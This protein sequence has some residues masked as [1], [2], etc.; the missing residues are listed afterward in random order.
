MPDE[1][2]PSDVLCENVWY[3]SVVYSDGI[4][5]VTPRLAENEEAVTQPTPVCPATCYASCEGDAEHLRCDAHDGAAL[6][7]VH[8][9][10]HA[11]SSERVTR[12]EARTVHTIPGT[13][14]HFPDYAPR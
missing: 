4:S 9:P 13:Q 8:P 6:R 3:K 10:D 5:G 1:S 12:A 2:L 7:A 11:A 14:G